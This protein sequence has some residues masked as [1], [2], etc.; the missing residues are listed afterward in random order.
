MKNKTS[1]KNLEKLKECLCVVGGLSNH[2]LY[3]FSKLQNQDITFKQVKDILDIIRKI[4]IKAVD[5]EYAMKTIFEDIR[6]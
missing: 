4:K 5:C 2:S 1:L 6:G 3:M